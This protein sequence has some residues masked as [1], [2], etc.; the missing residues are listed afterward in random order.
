MSTLSLAMIV[1]DAEPTLARVLKCVTGLC[2]ELVIVDTGS[3]DLSKEIAAQMGAKV[4]DFGW[5]DDF[6]AAR[7]CSF[8][9]C[10][11]DWIMWLDADDVISQ[12]SLMRLSEIKN[13]HLSDAIDAVCIP[14]QCVFDANNRCELTLYRERLLRRR[15]AL[16]WKYPVHECLTVLPE[17]S[18]FFHDA[19]IEHRPNQ[20]SRAA[21]V[22]D[23]NLKIIENALSNGALAQRMLFYY[24]NELFEHGRFEESIAAYEHFL[25]LAG[26]PWERYWAIRSISKCCAE[27]NQLEQALRWGLMAVEEQ[28]ERAEALNDVGMIHYKQN[29]FLEAI[30]YFLAATKFPK[31]QLTF[32][33]DFHYEWLPYDYLLKMDSKRCLSIRTA[34]D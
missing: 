14:Y 13:Q 11:G 7:N 20:Q 28:P 23:R 16:R 32:V 6:S 12:S 3:K 21:K 4:F 34:P 15:A 25:T 22:P 17:H 31:P 10:T 1:R 8:E 30:P 26:R 9:H 2:D 18:L 29:R 19:F 33:E 5:I 27:L 24:G